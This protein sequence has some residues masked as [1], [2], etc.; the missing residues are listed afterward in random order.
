MCCLTSEAWVG[1]DHGWGRCSPL[2]PGGG[3]KAPP[4]QVSPA[5]SLWRLQCALCPPGSAFPRVSPSREPSGLASFMEPRVPVELTRAVHVVAQQQLS[6]PLS[7]PSGQDGRD[8]PGAA[9]VGVPGPTPDT[10]WLRDGLRVRAGLLAPALTG[11]GRCQCSAPSCLPRR[12]R[13]RLQ[14]W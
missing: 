2:G 11:R 6:W 3:P 8:L 5:S 7:V 1:F 4:C 10:A 13:R 12:W 14:C 9:C